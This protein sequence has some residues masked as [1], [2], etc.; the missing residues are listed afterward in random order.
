M[1]WTR[2]GGI[3]VFRTC[4]AWFDLKT[5]TLLNPVHGLGVMGK[6]LARGFRS[7]SHTW[8][9]D[10]PF[11]P[12]LCRQ[13]LRRP[14]TGVTKPAWPARPVALYVPSMLYCKV[15]DRP[16]DRFEGQC[17]ESPRRGEKSAT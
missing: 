1:G 8:E 6:G 4:V 17:S 16:S 14:G 12:A 10:V 9:E 15:P 2:Q 5:Q 3:V 7:L 13:R 11:L